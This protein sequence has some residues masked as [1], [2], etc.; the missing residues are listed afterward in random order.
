MKKGYCGVIFVCLMTIVL[1]SCNSSESEDNSNRLDRIL[2]EEKIII[3][4]TGDYKPFTYFNSET[5]QYEGYDIEVAQKLGED[6]GVE[7]EFVETSWPTLMDDLL[8]DKFDI[9]MGGIT[10][11]LERQK[12]AHLSESYLDFGKAA[13]I[14]EEDFD[15]YSSLEA[16]DQPEV[17][18]GVNP[19]GTN[20]EF[21]T[22]N[23]NDAEIIVHENNLEIPGKVSTGEVD[24]MITDSVEA[25]LYAKEDD[26]LYAAFTID[27]FTN[28]QMGYLMHQGD[29]EFHNWIELWM[30]EMKMDDEF[31]TL[32]E[33]WM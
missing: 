20:E 26:N 5:G 33:E 25:I 7:V 9:A 6:L 8:E 27:T 23:I 2:E 1:T 15:N 16:I 3:G 22:N 21:V 12:S 31:Q 24:V 30:N 11:T 28:E 17:K 32:E 10:R 29:T 19:G 14:R 4:T 13:I 18:I